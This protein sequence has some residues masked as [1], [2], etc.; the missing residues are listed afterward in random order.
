[1][2]TKVLIVGN[3]R[4]TH[5]GRHFLK[6]ADAA[7]IDAQIMDLQA[8]YEGPRWLKS[9]CWH[10]LG[11]RPQ[12]LARFSR[13]VLQRCLHW[14][15]DLV[16]STGLAP[17]SAAALAHL[18][19][20]GIST[21]NFLTD[22]PWN[23]QH[24]TPS[25]MRALPLYDHVF[26]PRRANLAELNAL[27]GPQ[28]HYLPFAYAPEIHFAPEPMA[29]AE[30]QHWASEVLFIGGADAERAT[31]LRPLVDR[32]F[33]LGLWGGYWDRMSDFKAL[34]KGHA[35][36]DAFR[37]LVVSAGVNLCLVR[38]A[39]R[40]GHS[41]RTFELA[42]VGGC[43][44]V[45]DTVEHREI[46]GQEGECVCYFSSIA[47]LLA[48]TSKLLADSAERQRLATAVRSHIVDGG[49]HTYAARLETITAVCVPP[50]TQPPLQDAPAT[51]QP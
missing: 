26:S 19:R 10:L 11:K 17:L 8:A 43:L 32:G 34:A 51:T 7:G 45:E 35:D 50:S 29:P 44:A 4:E 1:M 14:K 46:F 42:A 15:P 47:E 40:D 3:P 22:D 2:R 21:A 25:F 28:V 6:G 49:R 39:N 33:K 20:L 37:R 5:V 27:Q 38:Q 16:L 41:M 9:L 24:R 18:R 12:R 13:D 30:R 23:P 36:E 48:L 31:V